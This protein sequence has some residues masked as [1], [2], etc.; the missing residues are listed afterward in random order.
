MNEPPLNKTESVIDIFVLSTSELSGPQLTEH[1]ED[2]GYQVT[3]FP[4]SKHLLETLREGKPNLLICDTTTIEDGFEVCRLVKA[5]SDLWVIPVLVF[6]NASTLADFLNVLDCNADNFLAFPSDLPYRLSLIDSMITTPVERQTPELIKTQF[7]INHED[8]IY[9]VAASRRKILEL[10]LSSFE[11]AVNKSSDL[12]ELKREVQKLTESTETLAESVTEH[13]CVIDLLNASVKQ[14]EQKIA[15]L[16]S[17]GAEKTRTLLQNTE[18]IQ[19]LA[20]ELDAEKAR[21]AAGNEKINSMIRE[22]EEIE[23]F[24]SSETDAL[25][26]QVADLLTRLEN[27]QAELKS[28]Q[29]GFE[30]EKTHSLSLEGSLQEVVAQK[31]EAEKALCT[32]EP[33]HERLKS[34]FEEEK[35]NRI[36]L[37][38]TLQK[39]VTQKEEA[40]KALC[41][42]ESEHERLKSA[43]EEEK[44]N[45][46]SL[47]GALQEVV[48]Q[49]EEAE[50]A[51][52][53][54][55]SEHGQLKSAYDTGMNRVISAEQEIQAITRDKVQVEQDLI[56]KISA[57]DQ[58]VCQRDADLALFRDELEKEKTERISAEEQLKSLRLEKEQSEASHQSAIGELQGQLDALQEEYQSA[59]AAL[60]T[61]ESTIQSLE[62]NLAETLAVKEKAEED[63]RANKAL[64]ETTLTRLDQALSET[65]GIRSASEADLAE[66]TRQNR[67]YAEG[68]AQANHEKEQSGQEVL[69]LTAEL[70]TVK[71]ELGKKESTITSLKENLAEA[72]QEKENTETR[73]KT[74]MESY[75]TTFIR[76]K[77]DL[78]ETLASR[79]TLEKDLAAEKIR[80]T[81]YAEE[82]ALAS[83]NKEQSGQ[84]IH[85]LADEIERLKADLEAERELHQTSN[86][87]REAVELARQRF[88]QDLRA[89]AEEQ[90]SLN[91]QLENERTLR[92]AAE[93]KIHGAALEEKRLREELCTVTEE[94]DRQEQDRALKI[95]TLKKDLETICDLQKSLEEEVNILNEE[96]LKSEQKVLALTSE[97][98][99]ARTA[100][101]DEWENHMTSDEQ[102]AAAVQER[103]RLQQS[104]AQPDLTDSDR[105]EIEEMIEIEPDQPCSPE[106]VT[107][108]GAGPVSEER[109]LSY[110]QSPGPAAETSETVRRTMNFSEIEDLF[111]EDE[112]TTPPECETESGEEGTGEE[113]PPEPGVP[114]TEEDEPEGGDARHDETT[115]EEPDKDSVAPGLS[116]PIP[117]PVFSFTRRQWLSLI[118]W[119]HHSKELTREQR[120]QIIRMG[121]LIQKNRRLT[122]EQEDQVRE[123]IA[124][125]QRLGYKPG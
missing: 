106:P 61:R 116:T 7:K 120:S 64:H 21:V 52:C 94:H 13:T 46:I 2:K 4:D 115:V 73:V 34:A 26:Q 119:A 108:P 29:R 75:K 62:K 103:Q 53:M 117:S 40:E 88:E 98:E 27:T 20:A 105:G 16:T 35:A 47:E 85:S 68:L 30:E 5:D 84:R 41:T 6:T 19:R 1:L 80:N 14:K 118:K 22:K 18:E 15:T 87:K 79:R 12:S 125:V 110:E 25:R 109:Q 101:A 124:M 83:R 8:Q 100:L 60:E 96:K 65:A 89:A 55:E 107:S 54:L 37:E 81:E 71:E 122:P 10:L 99:Q 59:T 69:T 45:R 3:I 66:V 67:E 57:L 63:A 86:E 93:E 82:L 104:L 48:A 44:A 49:K 111:E 33:E 58:A 72:L 24:H 114:D 38:G 102:L 90:K 91:A 56:A 51:L 121:R 43:F 31:E 74:D 9:V 36:S 113:L 39:V 17:E 11:I 95:Q 32:L 112:P 70:E 123:M 42:L 76:L 23:S 92:L 77:R 28:V 50:K 78:D 97:L